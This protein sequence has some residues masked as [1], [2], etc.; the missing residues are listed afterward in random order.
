MIPG[1]ALVFLCSY[2]SCI[3]IHRLDT[4]LRISRNYIDEEKLY[5]VVIGVETGNMSSTMNLLL[6][7]F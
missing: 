5:I 6:H 1:Y 3:F 4:S 7:I 2:H